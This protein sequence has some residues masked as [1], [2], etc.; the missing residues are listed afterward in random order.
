MNVR[1]PKYHDVMKRIEVEMGEA[2][3]GSPLPT[4][5]DLADRFATSRTTVRQALAAM[6]AD[7]RLE[8]VQG[9]GTFIAEPDRVVV[10]QLT[11]Y[12][13]DLRSQGREPSS[14]LLGVVRIKADQ[15]VAT[16]LGV[17]IGAMVHRIERVRLIDGEPLALEVAHLPGDLPRLRAELERCGSLYQTMREVYGRTLT[18]AKDVVEAGRAA[19]RE[20]ALLNVDVGV[21]LLIIHRTGF[22]ANEHAMEYTRSAFRGDRFRFAAHSATTP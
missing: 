18:H 20:A 15:E 4:E 8:R 16:A 14:Q 10:N 3:P 12:S 7:G 2:G 5:R 21:P 9:K 6:A 13:E 1:S 11:S 17:S 19:P 22:D